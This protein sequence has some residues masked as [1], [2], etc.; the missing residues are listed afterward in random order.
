MRLSTS[1]ASAQVKIELSELKIQKV[2]VADSNMYNEIRGEV[3]P[4]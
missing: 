3:E 2:V 1:P 4:I